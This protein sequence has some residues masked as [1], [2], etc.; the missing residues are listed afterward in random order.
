MRQPSLTESDARALVA[1]FYD[2]L[3]TPSKKDVRALIE[4][5][6]APGWRSHSANAVSKGRDELIQQ[7]MGFGRGIPDLA[8][9]LDEVLVAG[10]RIIVR[11]EAT[12]T[13]VGEFMGV[14]H[15]GRSFRI[16]TL[17]VHTVEDGRLTRADHVEDWAS[18]MR[19]LR[20]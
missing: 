9:T 20:G 19:Q 3:N 6:T 8:W 5:V 1:P 4:S 16:M 18:A 7:V 17:D 10:S 14:A 15:T 11:S 13:P 2:A 12:G